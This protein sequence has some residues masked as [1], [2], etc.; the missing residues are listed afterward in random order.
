MAPP[1]AASRA[2][3]TLSWSP[4]SEKAL[5]RRAR[6]QPDPAGNEPLAERPG[7]ERRVRSFDGTELAVH[8]AGSEDAPATLVFAHGFTLDLTAPV[9]QAGVLLLRLAEQEL[10][11][12]APGL[13]WESLQVVRGWIEESE[14][15][16]RCP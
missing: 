9:P 2:T 12:R 7:P 14:Q 4:G 1:A 11:S 8:L 13:Q 3:R 5:I 16:H 6:A 10:R 15:G